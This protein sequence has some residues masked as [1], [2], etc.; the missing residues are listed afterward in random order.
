MR[1]LLF[2]LFTITTLFGANTLE[3]QQYLEEF[4]ENVNSKIEKFK[5]FPRKKTHVKKISFDENFTIDIFFKSHLELSEDELTLDLK[6]DFELMN[7]SLMKR[8]FCRG[9]YFKKMQ[10]GLSINFNYY[11]QNDELITKFCL[12]KESC[13]DANTALSDLD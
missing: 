13:E 1:N 5:D 7:K 12:E 9:E 3:Q 11:T 8:K 4:C 10:E 2:T 6:D